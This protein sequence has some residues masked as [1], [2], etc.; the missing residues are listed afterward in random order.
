MQILGTNVRFFIV[1]TGRLCYTD[2]E[3]AGAEDAAAGRRGK[4]CGTARE[5]RR[6]ERK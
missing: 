5:R 6:D 2:S 4:N 3:S 1:K